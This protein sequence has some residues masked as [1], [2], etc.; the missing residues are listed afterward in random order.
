MLEAIETEKTELHFATK[1]VTINE[2]NE[3]LENEGWTLNQLH[4][5]D[6]KISA[7]DVKKMLETQGW[8]LNK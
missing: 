7:D 1:K 5:A 2:A 4:F 3:M 8:V 6:K